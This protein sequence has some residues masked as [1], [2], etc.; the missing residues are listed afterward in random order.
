[1]SALGPDSFPQPSS[2]WV[3]NFI[4]FAPI[5]AAAAIIRALL[6]EERATWGWNVRR[7]IAA[8]ITAWIAGPALL[9]YIDNF[10]VMLLALGAVSYA[11]PEVWDGVLKVVKSA[12]RLTLDSLKKR[13]GN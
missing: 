5:G 12:V 1:M 9:A 13:F 3:D 7:T 8:S 11:G 2:S 4:Q 6:S 10:N